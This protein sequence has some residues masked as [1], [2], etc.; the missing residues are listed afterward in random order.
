[1]NPARR[2]LD[3][4]GRI[5][6]VI[7]ATVAGDVRTAEARVG[8]KARAKDFERVTWLL[9]VAGEALT[10][11]EYDDAQRSLHR[12]AFSVGEFLSGYD[13]WL[14]PTLAAPPLEIGEFRSKGILAAAEAIIGRLGLGRLGMAVAVEAIQPV[15]R[16]EPGTRLCSATRRCSRGVVPVHRLK[17]R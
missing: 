6:R 2:A 16:V 10:S 8:R 14:T 17:A 3:P 4:P 7:F 13:A 11:G 15:A 5:D 9:R 12:M 1:M